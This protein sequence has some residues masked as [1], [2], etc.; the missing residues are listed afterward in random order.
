MQC[1]LYLIRMWINKGVAAL[2]GSSRG[3]P[4]FCEATSMKTAR[5]P[6]S[7]KEWADAVRKAVHELRVEK[8]P[9]GVVKKI[10]ALNA[11]AR[12]LVAA[13][14]AGDMTAIREIGDRLD[15]RAAQ[16]VTVK[17]DASHEFIAALRAL[18]SLRPDQLA[19]GED[20]GSEPRE[21]APIRH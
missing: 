14:L 11:L 18:Q 3:G 12:N 16:S 19:D 4:H 15:G 8:S 7:D 5:G 17:Q 1:T 2:L 20:M 13:G 9:D 10:R 21:P 6:K